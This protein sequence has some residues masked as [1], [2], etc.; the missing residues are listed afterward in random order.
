MA[1]ITVRKGN[2]PQGSGQ[3]MAPTARPG[4]FEPFRMM[5][6]LLR[7]DPFSEM[8]PML[9]QRAELAFVPDFDIKETRDGLV[10][11]ADLPG[12]SQDNLE[13]TVDRN[14]LVVQGRREDERTD[15]SETWY[16]TERSYGSF[17]RT[18]TLPDSTDLEHLNAALDSGVL[19]I[20][21]PKKESAQP[22][23]VQVTTGGK[24]GAK[25]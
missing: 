4:M 11:R 13:I 5:R 24:A 18:F 1:N 9:H 17:V 14:R 2:L 22:R 6:D 10:F 3:Q 12:L 19:T 16:A 21:I 8:L 25:S 23:K 15:E 20:T 7:F